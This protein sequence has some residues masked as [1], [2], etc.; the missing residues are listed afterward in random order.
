M[1]ESGLQAAKR[2]TSPGP[3]KSSLQSA[4]LH[5]RQLAS[6]TRHRTQQLQQPR[7]RKI[8]LRLRPQ[9]SQ[10]AEAASTRCCVVQQARLANTR[11]TPHNQR[12]TATRPGCLQQLIQ[13]SLLARA[14]DQSRHALHTDHSAPFR[15]RSG[16]A[17]ARGNATHAAIVMREPPPRKSHEPALRQRSGRSPSHCVAAKTRGSEKGR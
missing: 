13:P 17:L 16:N 6:T 15:K 7:E 14:A 11:L 12:T 3:A 9:R 8:R 10:H 4:P 2:S 1:G 5:L